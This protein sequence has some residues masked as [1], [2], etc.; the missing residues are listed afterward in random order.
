[1]LIAR[2]SS[3]SSVGAPFSVPFTLGVEVGLE[4]LG[5][6]LKTSCKLPRIAWLTGKSPSST[7]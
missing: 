6:R 4:R 5:R 7:F 3:L 2:A 1:M